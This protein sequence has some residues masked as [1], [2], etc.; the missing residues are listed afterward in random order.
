MG[1]FCKKFDPINTRESNKNRRSKQGLVCAGTTDREKERE[2]PFISIME[3]KVLGMEIWCHL[4]TDLSNQLLLVGM[5][6]AFS[7]LA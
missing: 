6:I 3:H 1:D 7:F 4:V 5:H 2:V